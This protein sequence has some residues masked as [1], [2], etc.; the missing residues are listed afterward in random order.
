[1]SKIDYKK[2]RLDVLGDLICDRMIE[3]KDN[4][5]DMLRQ[6]ELDD[7]GKYIRE[8]TVEE[9]GEDKFLIGIDTLQREQLIKMGR[10]IEKGS[11]KKNHWSYGRHYYISNINILE[12][13]LD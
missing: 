8:T 13:E 2:L 12:N 5:T 1:M 11:A 10:L 9:Y 6:L 3:C 7:E 4:R